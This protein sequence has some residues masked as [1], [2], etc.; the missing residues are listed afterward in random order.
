LNAPHLVDDSDSKIIT[1]R[2]EVAKLKLTLEELLKSL[3]IDQDQKYPTEMHI[4]MHIV[5]EEHKIYDSVFKEL[6]RQ[7]TV[8]MIERGNILAEIRD[9]YSR[10]FSKI[11]DHIQNLY[12]ELVAHRKLNSRLSEELNRAKENMTELMGHLQFVREHDQ[13][14]GQQA[15]EAEEKLYAILNEAGSAEESM[16]EFHNL[17]KMQRNRLESQLKESEKEKRLW[18]VAATHLA[19][20]IGKEYGYHDLEALEKCEEGRVRIT[21]HMVTI[22][23]DANHI[24]LR[25]LENKI[26]EW[27][28]KI[29]VISK[30]IV[31]EDSR[32]VEVLGKVKKMMQKILS[33]LKTNEPQNDIELGH[34]LLSNFNIHDVASLVEYLEYWIDQVLGISTRFTS[35]KDRLVRE[36]VVQCRKL[37]NNW[38]EAGYKL[39]RRNQDSTSGEEFLRMN[40]GL[41]NIFKEIFEWLYRLEIRATGEDGIASL[42]V[43]IQSQIEDRLALVK[44]SAKKAPLTSVERT[45][46][47][48]SLTYWIEQV[49]VLSSRGIN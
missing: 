30:S 35:G 28:L 27:R 12:T 3:S 48:Q 2:K 13:L 19:V 5:K 44:G 20:R 32:N 34:P 22:I 38:I 46:T 26:D 43:L 7:V 37:T 42:V 41:R 8:N 40:E 29:L 36:E 4:F 25:A 10:M 24:E 6:I 47:I 17:Y 14:V 49:G 39:L 1:T 31:E 21:N 23:G 45:Q 11:P 33:N 9:R 18:V 15:Y 16:E